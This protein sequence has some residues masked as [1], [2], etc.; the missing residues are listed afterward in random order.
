MLDQVGVELSELN[1]HY[2][3]KPSELKDVLI[4]VKEAGLCDYPIGM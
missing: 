3:I 4:K 1:G 2:A